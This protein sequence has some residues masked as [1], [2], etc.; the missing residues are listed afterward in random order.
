MPVIKIEW[1]SDAR[2][3]HFEVIDNGIGIEEA[4]S[5]KVFEIFKRLHSR[6]EYSGTGIGLAMCKRIVDL[7]GGSISVKRN[8]EQG[9]T[10]EF[11]LLNK[12]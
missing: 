1:H 8:S 9:S 5:E 6:H 11:S 3:L 7:Y 4:Y 2:Y 10:F 12:V